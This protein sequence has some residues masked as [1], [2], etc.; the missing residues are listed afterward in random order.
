M[1]LITFGDSWMWGDE[2]KESTPVYRNT[3][4]LGGVVFNNHQEIFTSYLNYSGNGSSNERI[5]LQVAEYINSPNYSKN[6]FLLIGLSSPL[7][8]LDYINEI[9]TPLTFPHWDSMHLGNIHYTESFKE[10]FMLEHRYNTNSRNEIKR[11]FINLFALK[12]L[13]KNNNYLVFQS[14]DNPVPIFEKIDYTGWEEVSIHFYSS[15]DSSEELLKSKL[16]FDI[17]FIKSK[18]NIG[19][20]EN[21]SWTNLDITWSEYLLS[22]DRNNIFANNNHLHPSEDGILEWYNFFIK[23]YI[24]DL[25]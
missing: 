1:K 8:R 24:E 25:K 5:I 23:K 20:T 19:T 13:I 15:V 2:L 17:D 10:W 4:N 9:K 12:G 7:R 18:L 3:H 16:L 22:I 21:Q 6:D 14:I 11:Y